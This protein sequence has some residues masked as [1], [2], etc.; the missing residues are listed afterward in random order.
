MAGMTG[1]VRGSNMAAFMTPSSGPTRR[2][3]TW[4]RLGATMGVTI[5]A[6][7]AAASGGSRADDATREIHGQPSWVVA[8]DDVEVAVTR[9][10][11]HMAPVTFARGSDRPIRPYHVSPWQEEGL[12]DLPAAVLVPLRGDFFCL[13]F[14]G[15]GEAFR[16]ERH[17]PHGETATEA[18]TFAGRSRAADG[19]ETL[20]LT[21]DTK[22]RSGRVTKQLT[23]R[24]GEPVVYTRHVV[25]G[26]AGPS[27][28][29]HHATLALPRTPRALAV[30][31]SPF[32]LGMTNPTRFSDPAAGEYQS[33][34]IDAVFTDLAKVPS[35][36]KDPP[37][38]DCTHFPARPGYADLLAVVADPAALGGHPAWTAAVNTEEHWAWFELRDAAVL[39]TTLFWI[40]DG[41]RHG[42]PWN[43]RNHC[44]GLED[45]CGAF[46]DGLAPSTRA[47]P[48]AD[49]GVRTVVEFDA[50]R[51]TEI[52]TIQGA[53]RVPA[54][55]DR[56]AR[57]E[58]RPAGLRLVATGGATVDVPVRHAFALGAGD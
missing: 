55:F 18:W 53:V 9:R 36:F 33:L 42:L 49:R 35:I 5:M 13:P 34:A 15:N 27:T 4:T 38:V 40:E 2:R 41:G 3:T 44:L 19:A 54:G 57:I 22:V 10:G 31:V 14:G 17:A 12:T 37:E 25:E 48:L 7:A 16:G 56:V 20:T 43:G 47:N 51:P 8:T 21:L 46:A 45:V 24:P 58:F 6:A 11:G 32:R 28:V 23:V 29:G 50:A 26:F 1:M 52:R 30:S 39:P